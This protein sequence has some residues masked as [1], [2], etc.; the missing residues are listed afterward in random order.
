MSKRPREW[1]VAPNAICI[2]SAHVLLQAIR[3]N[4]RPKFSSFYAA[5]VRS[6]HGKAKLIAMMDA[7]RG[8]EH[9]VPFAEA[10]VKAGIVDRNCERNKTNRNKAKRHAQAIN[11]KLGE[12]NDGAANELRGCTFR[13][14]KKTEKVWAPPDSLL[15][16][17][18]CGQ[19]NLRT[20]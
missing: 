20:H 10:I 11:F 7:L 8:T 9:D 6:E 2:G 1:E 18:D 5:C 14:T 16:D 17:Q 3:K 12:Q 13:K 4:F 19:A 15:L